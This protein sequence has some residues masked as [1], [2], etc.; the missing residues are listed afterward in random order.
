MALSFMHYFNN[1]SVTITNSTMPVTTPI[2]TIWPLQLIGPTQWYYNFQRTNTSQFDQRKQNEADN[3]AEA[4][5]RELLDDQQLEQ[6]KIHRCVDVYGQKTHQ[7]Y[8]LT[9]ARIGNVF[10]VDETDRRVAEYCIHYPSSIPIE[11]QIIAQKLMIETDEDAFL[12]I[13]NMAPILIEQ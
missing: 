1:S 10:H 5:L 7:L 9:K 13:A 2:T 8:R 6:W 3:R 12:Q 4:L 11:D